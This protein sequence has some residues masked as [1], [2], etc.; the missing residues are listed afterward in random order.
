MNNAGGDVEAGLGLP[1]M[2]YAPVVV[3]DVL[4]QPPMVGIGALVDFFR[5][6]AD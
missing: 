2:P 1:T 3:R 6:P 4:Q 5:A